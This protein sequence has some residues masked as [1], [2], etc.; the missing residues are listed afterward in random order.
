[1]AE[2]LKP[3]NWIYCV[4]CNVSMREDNRDEYGWIGIDW[5]EA[6]C[7]WAPVKTGPI[8]LE[9]KQHTK[10]DLHSMLPGLDLQ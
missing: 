10:N 3:V 7:S 5:N 9:C 6:Y 4:R 2:F 1:M 8:C